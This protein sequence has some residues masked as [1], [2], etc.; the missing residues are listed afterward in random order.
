VGRG[1]SQANYRR[2]S[3]G[4]LHAL[5]GVLVPVG[6]PEAIVYP[7]F[8]SPIMSRVADMYDQH[9]WFGSL[10]GQFGPWAKP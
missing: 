4:T 10:Q 2:P 6:G 7:L 1:R 5:P 3:Q 9:W 8:L